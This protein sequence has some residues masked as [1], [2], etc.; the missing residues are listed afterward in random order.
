MRIRAWVGAPRQPCVAPHNKKI[1]HAIDEKSRSAQLRRLTIG[2]LL[3]DGVL[4]TFL[5]GGPRLLGDFDALDEGRQLVGNR[6][7][8]LDR[9]LCR[10]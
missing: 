8:R 4:Q 9:D 5:A 1:Q 10:L 6:T 3:H 7:T 2:L